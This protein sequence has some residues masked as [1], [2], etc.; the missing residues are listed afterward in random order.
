MRRTSNLW[1]KVVAFESLHVAY[2]RARKGKRFTPEIL[3]FEADRERNLRLLRD[4]LESRAYRPGEYRTFTVRDPKPRLISAAPFRD[5]VVHHALVTAIGPVFERGFVF[6]SYANRVRKGTHA[7]IK[8]YRAWSE[9]FPYVLRCDVARFFPSMNHDVMKRLLRRKLKDPRVLE[10]CDGIIDGWSPGL[11]IGNLTSQ[12]FQNIYLDP[13]DHFVKETLGC[14]AYLRY[15]DDCCLLARDRRT[16]REWCGRVRECLARL[17]LAPNERTFEVCPTRDGV[18]WLGFTVS[19]TECIVKRT[20]RTRS[21]RALR[22]RWEAM[23]D[24]RLGASDLTASV[25]SWVAHVS[26]GRSGALRRHVLSRFP[27]WA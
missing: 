11:P 13:L 2:L 9:T 18:S 1:P 23:R 15:V 16:L 20:A 6:D 19:P 5:R 24:G 10:L 8:H 4:E 27:P 17:R 7:A 21:R 22:R 12:L 25:V 14:R 3:A 26:H